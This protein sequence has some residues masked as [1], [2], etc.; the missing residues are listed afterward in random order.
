MGQVYVARDSRLG[1]HVALKVLPEAFAHDVDR[2]ARFKREAQVLASFNHPHIAQIYGF[3]DADGMHALAMELVSGVTMADRIKASPSGLPLSDALELARQLAEGLAAAHEHGVIH[4]DL[5]PANIKITDDGVVKVLDFGLAKA[6]DDAPAEQSNAQLANSP[7]ITSPA[8]TA[9]GIILG[10]AA[11]MAPE[12]ARGHRVDKRADIWAF[13]CVLYEMLTGQ[14]PFEGE[15]VSDTLASVLKSDPDW[16]R[17][18]IE[19]PAAIRV[20]VERCL[21]KDRR[22]R[23]GDISAALF[24]LNDISTLAPATSAGAPGGR[25]WLI[26]ML[27]TAAA[28]LVAGAGLAAL[29][30]GAW[31]PAA[32]PGVVRR[33]SIVLPADH[34]MS[35]P[36]TPGSSI[37]ISRPQ[38]GQRARR[39]PRAATPPPPG[40]ASRRRCRATARAGSY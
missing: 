37:A 30:F 39:R 23:I 12:Q 3:E 9:M 20:L 40:R 10:T 34:P 15:D 38:A 11:Y 4:R 2:L 29:A 22:K 33:V 25:R 28:G 1:R 6:A 5:K 36:S 31:S 35:F 14:R 24:V 8:A 17:L 18:P 32:P 16:R 13:G 26:P 27:A 7:T 21:A 19:L